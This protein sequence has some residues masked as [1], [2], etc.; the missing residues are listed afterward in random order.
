[1]YL[2]LAI[3]GPR[4]ANSVGNTSSEI[5]CLV[6]AGRFGVDTDSILST[7]CTGEAAA[8]VVSGL[9]GLDLGLEACRGFQLALSVISLENGAVLDLDAHKTGRQVG[10]GSQPFLGRPALVGED[11]LNK[12]H[13]RQGITDSLVD[14]IRQSLEGFQGMLLSR[15]LRLGVL[16]DLQSVL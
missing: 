12:E 8:L 7:A 10:V 1:M 11:S 5:L 9:Q 14:Q 15:G 4:L 2:L 6:S 3:R 16:D 13:V